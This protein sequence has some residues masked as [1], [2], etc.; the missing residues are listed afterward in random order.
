MCRGPVRRARGQRLLVGYRGSPHEASELL[1]DVLGVEGIP[2]GGGKGVR[3]LGETTEKPQRTGVELLD[4]MLDVKGVDAHAPVEDVRATDELGKHH[5]AARLL[6]RLGEHVLE[7]EQVEPVLHRAIEQQVDH[8]EESKSGG[9]DEG[10]SAP[11]CTHPQPLHSMKRSPQP[12]P[13]HPKPAS[14]GSAAGGPAVTRLKLTV[15]LS[16]SISSPIS[17]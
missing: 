7:R 15:Q 11:A 9:G 13:H 6:D 4:D 2:E 3:S 12:H 16:G 8:T 14:C 10:I 5:C 17:M 1:D